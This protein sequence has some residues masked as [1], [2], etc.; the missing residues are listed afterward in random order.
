MKA[1][2]VEKFPTLSDSG[3]QV[4]A[5]V[6]GRSDTGWLVIGPDLKA[7][8]KQASSCLLAPEPGDRVLLFLLAGECWILAILERK[9]SQALTVSTDRDLVFR[10]IGGSVEVDG[11]KGVNVQSKSSISMDSPSFRLS[12]RI[13]EVVIEK[14][15]WLGH[16]LDAHVDGVCYVGRLF[17]SVVGRFSRRS[18]SSFREVEEI[19]QVRSKHVDYRADGNMS[20]RGRNVIAKAK[21]LV[22][23]DGD[24]IHMG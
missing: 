2:R 19:D 17:E 22:K 1:A 4:V 9:G 23:V 8:A 5:E 7:I 16:Q 21:D 15:S 11:A 24:Q 13:A 12:S 14:L 6:K 20:L 3:E 10:S 18:R